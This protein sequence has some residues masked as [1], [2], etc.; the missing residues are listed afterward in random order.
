[1]NH[2]CVPLGKDSG[3][4]I[5]SVFGYPTKIFKYKILNYNFKILQAT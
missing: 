1:M 4:P 5:M 2:H 3:N